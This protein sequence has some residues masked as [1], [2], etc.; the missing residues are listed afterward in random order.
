[1]EGLTRKYGE[2]EKRHPPRRRKSKRAPATQL[3]S[4]GQRNLD[5]LRNV[6]FNDKNKGKKQLDIDQA[7]LDALRKL[8]AADIAGKTEEREKKDIEDTKDK[9][10]SRE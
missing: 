9:E 4:I 7:S 2:G 10:E 8:N 1:M 6:N 3:P 5:A